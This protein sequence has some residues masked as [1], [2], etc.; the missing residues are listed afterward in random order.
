MADGNRVLMQEQRKVQEDE[1]LKALTSG[2]GALSTIAARRLLLDC[3][4][5]LSGFTTR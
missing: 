1:F 5:R 3:S 2:L 4:E